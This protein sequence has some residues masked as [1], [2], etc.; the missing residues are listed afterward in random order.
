MHPERRTV[1]G[2]G[3]SRWA[4]AGFLFCAAALSGARG[5]PADAPPVTIFWFLR[6]ASAPLRELVTS[7]IAPT[8]G[9]RMRLLRK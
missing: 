4:A 3:G 6:P 7:E 8:V 5:A 2:A 9:W 1:P